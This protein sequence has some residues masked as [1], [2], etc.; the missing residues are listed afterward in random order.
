MRTVSSLDC[1]PLRNNVSFCDSSF[2][3]DCY[4]HSRSIPINIYTM[5]RIFFDKYNNE[6]GMDMDRDIDG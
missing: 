4:N 2:P 1:P 3:L 6:N 5:A